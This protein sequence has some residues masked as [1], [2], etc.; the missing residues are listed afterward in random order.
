VLRAEWTK[1]RTVRGYYPLEPW[2]GVA[3][4]C[5]YAALAM[6]LAAV[7]LRRRDA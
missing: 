2:A 6:A 1:F 7:L 4:L 5:G 3:V